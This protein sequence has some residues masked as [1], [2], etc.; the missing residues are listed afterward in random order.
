MALLRPALA[1]P[2]QAGLS[3]RQYASCFVELRQPTANLI[4]LP[5]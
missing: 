4:A 5:D 1:A 3:L 2:V